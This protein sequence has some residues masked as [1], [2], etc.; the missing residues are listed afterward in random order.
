ML[1][2]KCRRFPGNI[3]GTAHRH[4]LQPTAETRFQLGQSKP[5]TSIIWMGLDKWFSPSL[6]GSV[7]FNQLHTQP[8]PNL[9]QVR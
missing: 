8:K 6:L 7:M 5:V 4:S 9:L 3:Q 1:S 2:W